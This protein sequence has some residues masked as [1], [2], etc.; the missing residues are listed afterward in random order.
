MISSVMSTWLS[1]CMW[2]VLVITLNF[3]TYREMQSYQVPF[4]FTTLDTSIFIVRAVRSMAII[5]TVD[6]GSLWSSTGH[7]IQIDWT[8]SL[9]KECTKVGYGIW[10]KE[11]YFLLLIQYKQLSWINTSVQNMTHWLQGN[12]AVCKPR[13][14]Q[15]WTSSHHTQFPMHCSDRPPHDLCLVL[16]HP[17]TWCHQYCYKLQERTSVVLVI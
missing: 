12:P 10:G 7:I 4:G 6:Q 16:S 9:T 5:G 1:W 3:F 15:Q 8:T 2:Q 11:H 14:H 17:P 13:W